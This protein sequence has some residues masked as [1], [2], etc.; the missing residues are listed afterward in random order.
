MEKDKNQEI[1]EMEY[2]LEDM[3]EKELLQA[4]D[5]MFLIFSE[6]NF[7]LINEYFDKLSII[8]D[9]WRVLKRRERKHLIKLAR[10]SFVYKAFEQLG[11]NSLEAAA[12]TQIK[13]A[14][15]Q[16]KEKQNKKK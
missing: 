4:Y 15:K 8:N 1:K 6:Q 2:G 3:S 7:D 11:K 14:Y 16:F 5:Q 9:L 10:I 13:P 12:I